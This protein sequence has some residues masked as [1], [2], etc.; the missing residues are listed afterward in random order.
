MSEP[1]DKQVE[2]AVEAFNS[3]FGTFR[4]NKIHSFTDAIRAALLA[5]DRAADTNALL[6][7][8]ERLNVAGEFLCGLIAN[9][10]AQKA[11]A[12][13]LYVQSSLLLDTEKGPPP[14]ETE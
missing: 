10:E 12:A 1:T 14:Q 8:R 7:Y 5:A 2:A 13:V 3:V 11:Y 6:H 9:P 4:D